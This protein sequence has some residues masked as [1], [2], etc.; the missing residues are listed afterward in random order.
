MRWSSGAARACFFVSLI[1][2]GSSLQEARSQQP[3]PGGVPGQSTTPASNTA[4]PQQKPFLILI[5][6]AHGGSDTGARITP[7]VAEKD[8]N[9]NVA[10]RLKQELNARGI[11]AQLLRDADV[12]LSADQRAATAN[13]TDAA[14]Y[15]ALHASS[16]GSGIRL[17][18][19]MLPSSGDSKGP[20]I[21]WEVAQST[22]LDRSKA[23]QAQLI[24]AIQQARFPVRGLIA[25]LRPLNNVKTPALAIEIS[26]T[27]GD[28]AQ[29][30]ST[31]YQQMVCAAI[32]NALS[33]VVSGMKANMGVRP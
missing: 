27:T 18:T 15:L 14:L 9:L 12:T 33:S 10:R 29:V 31:G 30:A 28:A 24:T 23:I 19:A 8:I 22:A 3:S 13:S 2:C 25:P 17:F 7:T 20:F 16:L 32:A 21:A 11:Q 6:P 1:L 26:P 5:D 4:V